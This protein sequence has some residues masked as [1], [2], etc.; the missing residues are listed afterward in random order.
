MPEQQNIEYKQSWH[1][2]YLKWVCGF[3][4]AVGGNIF[5]GKDDNGNVVHLSDY[6]K[7]M[8]EIPNKIRNLMGITV[9][10]N[11]F[12]E[13]GNRVIEIVVLPILFPYR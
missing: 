13:N 1:D 11:L 5:I 10:V 3:A 4:Y 2:D 9:E 8:D 6:K 7:L 12:E